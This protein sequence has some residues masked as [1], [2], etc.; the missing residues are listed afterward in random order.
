[1]PVIRLLPKLSN[2]NRPSPS[3]SPYA[4]CE[5]L[6]LAAKFVSVL[7]TVIEKVPPCPA[8]AMTVFDVLPLL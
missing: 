7:L 3:K 8:L 5:G 1:M 6:V 2:S 4:T